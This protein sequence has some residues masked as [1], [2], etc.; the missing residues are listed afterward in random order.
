MADDVLNRIKVLAKEIVRNSS[1][2][3][4]IAREIEELSL[5]VKNPKFAELADFI[6]QFH[7]PRDEPAL[8][9]L[10]ELKKKLVDIFPEIKKFK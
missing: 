2:P 8:Y 5:K 3:N 4:E 10:K 9:G 6:A 7:E 1:N